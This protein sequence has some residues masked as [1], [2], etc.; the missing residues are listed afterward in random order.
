MYRYKFQPF[1]LVSLFILGWHP[2]NTKEVFRK[3]RVIMVFSHTSRW[4]FVFMLLYS[5]AYLRHLSNVFTIMKPQPFVRCGWLLR[6]IGCIPATRAEISD[7]GFVDSTATFL[8]SKDHFILLISPQGRC[9]PCP[10]K[11]GYYYLAKELR[12]AFKWL[13]LIIIKRPIPPSRNI[14]GR[15]SHGKNWNL[16]YREK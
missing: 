1:V 7:L 5:G 15:I 4:D 12:C 16:S 10:W 11:S 6:W 2:L 3:R 8:S 13:D 9:I 14:L